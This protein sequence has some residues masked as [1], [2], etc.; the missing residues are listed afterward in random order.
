M[1]SFGHYDYTTYKLGQEITRGDKVLNQT[2][3][4]PRGL[5]LTTFDNFLF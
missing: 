5:T 2:S 1:D 4:F 3:K